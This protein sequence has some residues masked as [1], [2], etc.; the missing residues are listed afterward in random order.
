[1]ETQHLLMAMYHIVDYC[2]GFPC[3]KLQPQRKPFWMGICVRPRKSQ[4]LYNHFDPVSQGGEHCQSSLNDVYKIF[5]GSKQPCLRGVVPFCSP[6]FAT[7][8]TTIDN[9]HLD[10]QKGQRLAP[11]V[12]FVGEAKHIRRIH[13]SMVQYQPL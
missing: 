7:Y 4:M 13:E 9:F 6:M 8:L 10:R 3:G 1:M 2:C 11:Q 12:S 5:K